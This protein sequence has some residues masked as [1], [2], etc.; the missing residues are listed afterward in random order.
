M[1][2]EPQ[3]CSLLSSNQTKFAFLKNITFLRM[4]TENEKKAM[5][6]PTQ[7]FFVEVAPYDLV[8]Y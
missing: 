1:H 8:T 7:W 6:C 2:K 3:K 5:K 4:R